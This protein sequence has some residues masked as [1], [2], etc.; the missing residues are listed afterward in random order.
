MDF[1]FKPKQ[2]PQQNTI[3]L[4]QSGPWRPDGAA[5]EQKV[6]EVPITMREVAMLKRSHKSETINL[7]RATKVKSLMLI[8][9]S[10]LEIHVQL[11]HLGRGYGLSSIK[12]DHAALSIK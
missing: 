6:K 4:V 11:R 1:K 10:P 2:K 3:A 12:H 8:G 5:W 9:K 7:E